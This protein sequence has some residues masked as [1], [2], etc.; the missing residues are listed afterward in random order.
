VSNSQHRTFYPSFHIV[1]TCSSFICSKW[2]K[3]VFL[4]HP[5]HYEVVIL[6]IR[7][8]SFPVRQVNTQSL[9]SVIRQPMKVVIT[10][11]HQ[12]NQW[13]LKLRWE[14]K[15]GVLGD[16]KPLWSQL[17]NSA[18]MLQLAV[19]CGGKNSV[20]NNWI[21]IMI[22][23]SNNIEWFVASETSL[24]IKIIRKNSSTTF[25]VISKIRILLLS[26]N[27]KIPLENSCIV[28]W[29]TTKILSAAASHT[30]H[31][32]KKSS[33]FVQNVLSYPADRQTYKWKYNYR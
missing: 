15:V 4:S 21:R 8:V 7:C 17:H 24:S 25:W 13:R 3:S 29:I 23:I 32:S 20:K 30:S 5:C 16:C 2:F 18:E 22:R 28:N 31:F 12:C 1:L 33:K 26:L 10:Y 6:S 11:T 14:L 27:G 9:T 19:S